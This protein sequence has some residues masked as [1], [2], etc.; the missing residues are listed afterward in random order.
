MCLCGNTL[1]I[2]KNYKKINKLQKN[3]NLQFN[4]IYQALNI[5]LDKDK[6]DTS[7]KE[8]KKLGTNKFYSRLLV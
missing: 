3:T 5:L 4:D 8:R 6:R 1:R 2:I 7:Q